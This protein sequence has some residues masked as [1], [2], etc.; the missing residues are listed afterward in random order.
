MLTRY[1]GYPSLDVSGRESTGHSS[2]EAMA[3]MERLAADLP[4]GVAYEWTDTAFEQIEAARDTPLLLGLS[5]LA[6]F[7]VLAALYESWITPAAVLLVVPLGTLGAVAAM[8][9]RGLPN[10]IYFKV[11]LVTVVGLTAKNAILI[12]QAAN[13]R[14]LRGISAGPA[15][16]AACAERLRPI[17]MTSA[18]FVL[19]VVPLALSHSAGAESRHSIGTGVLGG[20]LAATALGLVFAPVLYCAV[21]ARPPKAVPGGSRGRHGAAQ[22]EAVFEENAQ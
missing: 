18:A 9:M 3:E 17:V 11:G 15:V 12:V 13:A 10:D 20:V 8:L 21:A 19:G 14:R 16:V 22:G 1:N 4:S 7:M 6:V 2:G 5:V